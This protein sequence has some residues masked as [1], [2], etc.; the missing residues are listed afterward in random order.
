MKFLRKFWNLRTQIWMSLKIISTMPWINLSQPCL[1]LSHLSMWLH[2]FLIFVYLIRCN[3]KKIIIFQ[4]VRSVTLCNL[5]LL[6]FDWNFGFCLI[7]SSK[8]LLASYRISFWN[9]KRPPS[10][11]S[12]L[13][14][15][16]QVTDFL[17]GNWVNLHY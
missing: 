1:V 10:E 4:S 5:F 2:L 14:L 11:I 16:P 15:N 8:F 12:L 17:Y 7:W 9:Q 6:F 13:I 3:M